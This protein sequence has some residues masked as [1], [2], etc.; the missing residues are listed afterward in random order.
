MIVDLLSW[1]EGTQPNT[2]SFTNYGIVTPQ[3]SISPNFPNFCFP[4]LTETNPPTPLH[5]RQEIRS[6]R[7]PRRRHL[8][9]TN[10]VAIVKVFHTYDLGV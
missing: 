3:L 1:V 2:H 4:Q 10:P 6:P 9:A 5:R 7:S 8:F